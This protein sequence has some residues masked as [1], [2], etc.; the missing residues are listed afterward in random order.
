MGAT[1]LEANLQISHKI[2]NNL[3]IFLFW[4]FSDLVPVLCLSVV[5]VFE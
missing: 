4:D 1:A 2:V 5:N 3:N